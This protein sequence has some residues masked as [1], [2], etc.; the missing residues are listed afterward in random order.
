MGAAGCPQ[1]APKLWD[2]I[3]LTPRDK[4]GSSYLGPH[5]IHPFPPGKSGAGTLPW[6]CLEDGS[7][8]A[9]ERVK[10]ESHQGYLFALGK[11]FSHPCSRWVL[12]GPPVQIPV[13]VFV[14]QKLSDM[15]PPQWAM[16]AI[17]AP[18]PTDFPWTGGQRH[19]RFEGAVPAKAPIAPRHGPASTPGY[20]P[21]SSLPP[22]T[23]MR[24]LRPSPLKVI[25]SSDSRLRALRPRRFRCRGCWI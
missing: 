9:L 1:T 12:L 22:V 4:T 23:S 18:R 11:I 2:R 15:Q 24:C 25:H 16:L 21:T 19:L 6:G 3:A 8:K 5:P 13:R 10:K 20:P 14:H 7:T 17:S